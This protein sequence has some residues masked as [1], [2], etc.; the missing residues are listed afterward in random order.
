[1]LKLMCHGTSKAQEAKGV[2]KCGAKAEAKA[3][4]AKVKDTA[5]QARIHW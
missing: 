5:V 4:D 2:A 3:Q 1:M